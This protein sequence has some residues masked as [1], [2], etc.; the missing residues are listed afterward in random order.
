MNSTN[1]H[2]LHKNISLGVTDTS[3][4]YIMYSTQDGWTPLMI[5]SLG[6]YVDTVRMLIEAKAQI[7]TQKEVDLC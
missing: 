4:V 1:I 6:G 5:A 2:V 7:D 3:P